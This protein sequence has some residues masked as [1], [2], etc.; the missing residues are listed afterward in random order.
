MIVVSLSLKQSVIVSIHPPVSP[1]HE[2]RTLPGRFRGLWVMKK[3]RKSKGKQALILNSNSG[4]AFSHF[5][6]E[7]AIFAFKME[8]A[9]LTSQI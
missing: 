2:S 3:R 5:H 7:G 1:G 9:T 6:E 4:T 8:R